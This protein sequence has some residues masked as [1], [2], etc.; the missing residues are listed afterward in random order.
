VALKVVV[1]F[2]LL[3]D[4][5]GVV[6]SMNAC[7]CLATGDFDRPVL[8]RYLAVV[9]SV[10]WCLIL[11]CWGL[12]P[13]HKFSIMSNTYSA[14]GS[15][16]QDNNPQWW[17]LFSVAMT[18][19][20]IAMVPVVFYN[21]R[22]LAIISVRAAGIGAFFMMLGG[23]GI[24]L[25]GIFPDAYGMAFGNHEIR[26]IHKYVAL[27]GAGGYLLCAIWFGGMLVI[28]ALKTEYGEFDYTR[29]VPPYVI[30]G[31]VFGTGVHFLL[32]WESVY[33]NLKAAA[34]AAGQPVPGHFG[35]ALN[36]RYSFPLWENLTIWSLFIFIVWFALALPEE[37]PLGGQR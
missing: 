9:G 33:A 25:V 28:D 2:D 31:G 4:N 16:D 11:M 12:F 13:E 37:A 1:C 32:R 23:I 8:Q 35:A 22:R 36:T 6:N 27:I 34:I 19:W 20:G 10:Y 14:L 18:F 3:L 29:L 15:Y 24:S 21:F 17:W 30:L 5:D 26:E 7:L